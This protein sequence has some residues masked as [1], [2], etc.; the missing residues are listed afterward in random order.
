MDSCV[1]SMLR[2]CE[3]PC[4]LEQNK[5]TQQVPTRDQRR[6]TGWDI[7]PTGEPPPQSS[8]KDL[9]QQCNISCIRK[10]KMLPFIH[11]QAS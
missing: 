2:L 1:L 7:V 9:T 5:N 3:P 10:K 4:N 8:P 6:A 11:Q